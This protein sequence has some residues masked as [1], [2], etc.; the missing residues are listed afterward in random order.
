M[1]PIRTAIIGLS[2]S[3]VTSWASNAHLPYLLSPLGRSKYEIVALLN[4]SVP[5]A[6]AAIEAFKLS[7]DTKAYGS[8]ADLASDPNVDLVVCATRVDLHYQT[9]KPSIE[10]GKDVFVEWPLAQ[11]VKL[12]G[13]LVALLGEKGG[14]SVIGL[15]G[16]LAPPVVKIKEL[17]ES[18]RIGKV[19]SVEA[20]AFGGTNDAVSLP[21][22]LEYF[23][24]REVGGNI[25]TIL[26]AHCKFGCCV[27]CGTRWMN[28]L[29]D[30]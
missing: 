11:N 9:I 27:P 22:G 3:A 15:Q 4:S 23:T 12:A 8:P 24:R 13:E 10:A 20:R 7:P 26:F 21:K 1:A 25:Y 18:G 14:R 17:I 2:S 5:A 29:T 28:E 19:L 30:W 6:K 16:R